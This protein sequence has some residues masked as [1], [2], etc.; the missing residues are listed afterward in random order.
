[1]KKDKTGIGSRMGDF[2]I[3]VVRESE[4]KVPKTGKPPKKN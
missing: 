3:E 4:K 1:M 2:V